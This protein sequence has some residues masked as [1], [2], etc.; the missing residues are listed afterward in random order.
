[1]TSYPNHARPVPAGVCALDGI[2]E[3]IPGTALCA[4]HHNQ[5]GRLLGDLVTLWGDLE[6][7]RTRKSS[8]PAND[9]VKSSTFFDVSSSWNPHAAEELHHIADWARFLVRTITRDLDDRVLTEK[10]PVPVTL[11]TIQRHYARWLS[12]YPGIA[13]LGLALLQ[14]ARDLRRTALAAIQQEPVRRVGY[15]GVTCAA[16][17]DHDG[18]RE[19]F[20]DAPLVVVLDHYGNPGVLVC[21]QHPKTHYQYPREEWMSLANDAKQSA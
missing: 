4:N 20:C 8:T 14:D 1:M 2:N 13:P 19:L 7:S 12:G 18:F 6:A 11:A 17:V 16:T 21:S 10:T 15:K 3:R 9:R 5:F